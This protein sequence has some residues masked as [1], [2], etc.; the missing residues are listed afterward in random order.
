M[1]IPL[2]NR[3][4]LETLAAEEAGSIFPKSIAL[5]ACSLLPGASPTSQAEETGFWGK[6]GVCSEAVRGGLGGRHGIV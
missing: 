2:A 3:S 5:G 4:C 6:E 1:T